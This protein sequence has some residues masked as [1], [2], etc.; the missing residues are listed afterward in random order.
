MADQISLDSLEQFLAATKDAG[1]QTFVN[2]LKE[3]KK[4]VADI[5]DAMKAA[6]P[7]IQKS[8]QSFIDKGKE[9]AE[10]WSR[11]PELAEE[12]QRVGKNL[13]DG[14]TKD[15]Q[16]YADSQDVA[17]DGV[18]SFGVR[19]ALAFEPI[20]HILPDAIT[21][22]GKFGDASYEAGSKATTAF[23]NIEPL[24][25]KIGLPDTFVSYQKNLT[26]AATRAYTMERGIVSLAAAQ[27]NLNSMLDEGGTKFGNL[28]QSFV[29]M[30]NLAYESAK[31]TN[32]TVESMMDLAQTLGSIPQSL[33]EPIQIAGD[34]MSQL[35]A[36]S[37][38]A[39]AFMIPQ[40]EVAKK[41]STMYTEM[42]ISGNHAFEALANIY[43]KAGDSKLRFESFT[44]TVMTI[45]ESFKMLGDNTMAATT[46]VKAF[47]TAFK[48][49]NISPA[50]MQTVISGMTTGIMEMDR[51][52]EAF[53]SSQTGGP[54]GL[55]GA[56]EMEY[57]MQ[58]GNMN[59]V[60]QKTMQAMQ[61]QFG[62]PALTLKDV[63]ENPAMAGEMYKQV[64]YLTQVA[65]IAKNDRDAYRILEAM[66]SGVTDILAPGGG[67]EE[68]SK[69]LETATARGTAEQERTTSAVMRVNQELEYLKLI[70]TDTLRGVSEQTRELFG[71][72]QDLTGSANRSATTGLGA[73]AAP[74]GGG[75]LVTRTAGQSM[76]QWLDSLGSSAI[77]GLLGKMSSIGA[78]MLG[79]GGATPAAPN[80]AGTGDVATGSSRVPNAR[81]APVPVT[82]G[83]SGY[84]PIPLNI[85]SN[86]LEITVNFKEPFEQKVKAIADQ[87][88][89]AAQRGQVRAGANGNSTP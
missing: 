14:M 83:Q 23:S 33:T 85:Q 59:E 30:A 63:H 3:A 44:H 65:G 72:H 27:G 1:L 36:T 47:D 40:A 80:F 6:S 82:Q 68:G 19:A 2:S 22:M 56:Y 58:Q 78:G 62:N 28:N 64:Q 5:A 55:A 21:G 50:A 43:E 16:E 54:G 75:T 49:S 4:G 42:G 73:M 11:F 61:A 12:V 32:Q 60:L 41:L 88:I 8:L 70:Q 79:W 39:T 35:A 86:P 48:G 10:Q 67:K 25:K 77:G 69:A 13:W 46:V 51:A 84:S 29:D 74:G 38:L 71:L 57:A 26:E 34:D 66:K 89:I 53:V 15:I 7:E 52:K 24:L 20:V 37:K 81:Y 18:A 45:A 9:L 17:S 76:D 31:A 87:R